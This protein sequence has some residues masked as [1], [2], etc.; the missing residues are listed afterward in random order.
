MCNGCATK[1][2]PVCR[3]SFHAW[4]PFSVI[5][6]ITRLSVQIECGTCVF[7]RK[8]R[9]S[10][11]SI[12]RRNRQLL[13]ETD[14]NRTSTIPFSQIIEQRLLQSLY[15]PVR[16]SVCVPCIIVGLVAYVC[17]R[18]SHCKKVVR[19]WF[20]FQRVIEKENRSES[21]SEGKK[22]LLGKLALVL[23]SALSGFCA[24]RR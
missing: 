4:G 9:T 10:A 11:D 24:G 23:H 2:V 13:Q 3:Q 19:C 21:V 14:N 6:I 5:C 8:R 7:R 12:V 15:G 22:V 1:N 20:T 17:I 18:S 16:G